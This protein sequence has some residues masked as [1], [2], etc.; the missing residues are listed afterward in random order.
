MSVSECPVKMLL[1][2]VLAGLNRLKMH[3]SQT[4]PKKASASAEQE[5]ET[6]KQATEA[7]GGLILRGRTLPPDIETVT[8]SFLDV[9]DFG[10]LLFV[11]HA[12]SACTINAVKKLKRIQCDLSALTKPARDPER[13]GTVLVHRFCDALTHLLP[14]I[15]PQSHDDDGFAGADAYGGTYSQWLQPLIRLIKR[16]RSTLRIVR[17]AGLVWRAAV[18]KA[19]VDCPRLEELHTNTFDALK[20]T[21]FK[22]TAKQLP[23][24]RALTLEV[25]SE[26]TGGWIPVGQMQRILS[27]RTL[28]CCWPC[29]SHVCSVPFNRTG[30]DSK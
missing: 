2:H 15:K 16:N 25:Q 1:T 12:L 10:S 24:L 19:L 14:K 26:E 29:L 7:K 4:K 21:T 23:A 5:T 18:V 3:R 17:T 6:K 22:I 13:I 30:C 28:V 27:E 11:S 9:C 8:L 20:S